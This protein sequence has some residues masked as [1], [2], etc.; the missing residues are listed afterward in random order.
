MAEEKKNFWQTIGDA[1]K[2]GFYG[3]TGKYLGSNLT[4]AEQ[5]QNAFQEHM[6]NTAFQRQVVDMQAAGVNPALMYGG[7]GSSGAP[8]PAGAAPVSGLNP[9]ADALS[10]AKLYEEIRGMRIANENAEKQGTFLDLQNSY[11]PG[12]KTAEIQNLL[13][14]LGVKDSVIGLNGSESAFKSA[15]T[16]LAQIDAKYRDAFNDL[17]N[18]NL[19]EEAKRKASDTARNAIETAIAEMEKD[20]GYRLGSNELLTLATGIC[21]LFGIDPSDLPGLMPRLKSQ[22]HDGPLKLDPHQESIIDDQGD[23]EFINKTGNPFLDNMLTNMNRRARK[24][25]SRRNNR[26]NR[27]L[28]GLN[29]N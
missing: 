1:I 18:R 13:K 21:S 17:T 26:N 27:A 6:A 5:E 19:D 9:I 2:K 29:N 14:D 24:R 20:L 15:Q 28:Q 4:P 8:A 7:A 23:P 22:L 3:L 12:L 10:S 11:F 16:V 25:A